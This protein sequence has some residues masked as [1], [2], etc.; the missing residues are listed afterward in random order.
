MLEGVV[1]RSGTD[2]VVGVYSGAIA[3]TG[4]TLRTA[5]GGK[6]PSGMAPTVLS[7]RL[8]VMVELARRSRQ[9]STKLLSWSWTRPEGP[10]AT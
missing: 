10:L 5:S 2:D 3:G 1:V 8:G 7:G 9:A 6:N 4:F